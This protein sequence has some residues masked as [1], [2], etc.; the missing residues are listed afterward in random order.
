LTTSPQPL[1]QRRSLRE[2][3][4]RLLDRF[5]PVS[6][7]VNHVNTIEAF[8]LSL[9]LA[10]Q[11][12]LTV[13]PLLIVLAAFAPRLLGIHLSSEL[14]ASLGLSNSSFAFQRMLAGTARATRVGGAL[15][16]VLVVSAGIS[17]ATAM[18]R[19]YERI[20]GLRRLGVL[21][22]AWRSACWLAACIL[23]FAVTGLADVTFKNVPGNSQIFYTFSLTG[24]VLFWWW[25]PRLLL[26]G[27]ASWRAALPTGVITGG[28]LAVLLWISPLLMPGFVASSED[29]FGPL[30]TVFVVMLWLTIVCSI[31]VCCGIAGHVAATD[32]RIS[33]LLRLDRSGTAGDAAEAGAPGSARP[34]LG[35]AGLADARPAQ[36]RLA[37]TD[38]AEPHGQVAQP[39]PPDTGIPDGLVAGLDSRAGDDAVGSR[40]AS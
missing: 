26:A 27:R 22:S 15:G 12:F 37:D 21:R 23:V 29:E 17:T 32:P 8:D 14:Q 1:R 10:A 16:F 39:R 18:Q 2:R 40:A 20:W 6:R 11:A 9:V 13:V 4:R 34:L 28:V 3:A 25:T 35:A 30:G 19:C 33:R 31:I 38:Q 7:A 24:A 5:D 36:A